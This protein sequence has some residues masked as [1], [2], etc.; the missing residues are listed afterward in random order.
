MRYLVPLLLLLPACNP[1]VEF[2]VPVSGDTTVPAGTVLEQV[3]DQF[4]FNAFTSM[5][6]SQ[7]DQFKVN[8]VRKDQ[9]TST[10]LTK[11]TMTIK[12]PAGGN[13]DWLHKIQ[14]EAA[15]AN[16]S[17]QEVAHHDVPTGVSTFNCDLDGVDLA[18]YVKADS[19]SI[20]TNA[21]AQ[22]PDSDTTVHVDASF[23]V[24]AQ[25]LGK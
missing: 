3:L 19:M 17:T 15:A 7:S 5:D 23:H 13:F 9:V 22:H 2:D 20:T 8:D 4:G 10:K 25:V 16:V 6:I 18:P 21:N 12:A 11:L 1:T 14:F 24:T